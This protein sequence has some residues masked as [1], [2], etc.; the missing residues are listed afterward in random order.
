M[1]GFSE[2][3]LPRLVLGGMLISTALFMYGQYRESLGTQAKLALAYFAVVGFLS[4][5][6]AMISRFNLEASPVRAVGLCIFLAVVAVHVRVW[7]RD[8]SRRP[9]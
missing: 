3:Q 7:W 4:I 1:H 6:D 8:R 9:K 5:S 2:E